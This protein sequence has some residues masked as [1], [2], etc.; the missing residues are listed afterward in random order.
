MG[1]C[2]E[3]LDRL[4]P[5]WQRMLEHPFLTEARDGTLDEGAFASWLREDYLFVRSALPFQAAL[6]ARAPVEE[7]DAHADA[8]RALR[9]ELEL[10]RERADVLG[11]DLGEARPSFVTHAYVQFLLA[12]AHGRSYPEGHAVLYVAE[13]AYH[14]SWKVVRR[15]LDPT[16]PWWPFVENWSGEA[17]G[18]FVRD[19]EERQDRL[20]EGAGPAL[21][22]QMADLFETTVR[23][24]IAFW[25]MAY[26]ASRWPGIVKD[27]PGI[28]EEADETGGEGA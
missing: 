16:H 28:E 18:A 25:E 20:A 5:L 1:F 15:G 12:T 24:E 17:F 27:W 10:F 26:S 3:Q 4:D 19:L 11:I 8:I 21:R 7:R 6:L 14:E 9:E 13:K 2:R 22:A 23:Y